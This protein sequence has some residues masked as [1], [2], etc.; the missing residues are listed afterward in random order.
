MPLAMRNDPLGVMRRIAAECGDVGG[1]RV[2]PKLAV[3]ANSPA[4]VREVL[5]DHPQD[6]D[7]GRL[8]R[9]ALRPLMGQGLLSSEGDLHAT[10]RKLI[11][12]HF[13]VRRIAGHV[14]TMVE[15]ADRMIASWPDGGDVDLLDKM[16][17]LTI[18]IVG[19]VLLST[20][21]REEDALAAAMTDAFEWE[22]H[23][24][25]SAFAAPLWV[26]TPL[27]LRMKRAVRYLRSRIGEW[28]RER[29]ASGED[30]GDMLSMLMS[31]R[32]EDGTGMSEQQLFDETI[33]LCGAAQETSADAQTWVLYLLARHPDVY[34]RVREEVDTVL[35][36]R[37]VTYDDLKELPYSLQVFKETLRLY[38]PA[39]IMLRG[40]IRDT[41]IGG[42]HVP[43]GTVVLISPYV[44]HRRESEY[45]DPE[46]FDPSR[47]ERENERKL[48]KYSFLPFGAGRRVCIGNHFALMEGHVL[49]VTLAQRADVD[50]VPD[51]PVEE[52]LLINLRPRHGL[53]A[54]VRHRSVPTGAEVAAL[55]G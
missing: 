51:H 50:L 8:Q 28:I 9:R 22:M 17:E 4:A 1:V 21:I 35:G 18:D 27:N 48:P 2:G 39:S 33:T 34:A 26:P 24:F 5:V 15:V 49:T 30:K 3:V 16:N 53:K 13:V 36:G 54:R 47:F 43:K 20:E 10:Q 7:K 25:T 23:A 40:A 52:Q 29:Q 32:Y 42:Y 38:P 46:R 31:L 41:T 19:R 12:P 45:P 37:P 44:L 14:D 6:F 55:R 11:Q